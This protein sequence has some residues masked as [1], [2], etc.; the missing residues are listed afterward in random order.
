MLRNWKGMGCGTGNRRASGQWPG[1]PSPAI[2]T[3]VMLG[4]G[5]SVAAVRLRGRC[6]ALPRPAQVLVGR[7]LNGEVLGHRGLRPSGRWSTRECR[8]PG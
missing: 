6:G 1:S 7:G 8:G 2:V 5:G 4:G 3:G